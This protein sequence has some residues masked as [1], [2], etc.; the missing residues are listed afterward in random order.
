MANDTNLFLSSSFS[1]SFQ[2]PFGNIKKLENWEKEIYFRKI[3]SLFEN[4]EKSFDFSPSDLS[5]QKRS[6]S[7]AGD[8]SLAGENEMRRRMFILYFLNEDIKEAIKQKEEA[9][10]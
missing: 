1:F 2:R 3:C 7:T 4:E 8:G 9:T 10:K 5:I 6:L